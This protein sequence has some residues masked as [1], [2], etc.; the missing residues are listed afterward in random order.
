MARF[1]QLEIQ[2]ELV[3]PVVTVLV[4]ITNSGTIEAV[5]DQGSAIY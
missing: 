5:T 1:L 4:T 2:L 3:N